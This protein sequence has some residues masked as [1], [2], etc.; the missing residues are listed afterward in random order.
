MDN[1]YIRYK[2]HFNTNLLELIDQWKLK[3][4]K[5][6]MDK[7][8]IV[9][10]YIGVYFRHSIHWLSRERNHI[11]EFKNTKGKNVKGVYKADVRILQMDSSRSEKQGRK[12]FR[13]M[14][15]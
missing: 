3:K 10:E 2:T 7:I 6:T 4:Q 11:T 15:Q 8:N 9:R 14:S 5:K 1:F 12:L 13:Q